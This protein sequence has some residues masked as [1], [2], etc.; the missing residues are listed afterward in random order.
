MV[1]H[2]VHPANREGAWEVEGFHHRAEAKLAADALRNS[3]SGLLR[4]SIVTSSPASQARLLAGSQRT[5][6]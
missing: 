2:K 1:L 4:S 6:G 5:F 3:G